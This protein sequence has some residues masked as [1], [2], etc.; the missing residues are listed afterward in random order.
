LEILLMK[1]VMKF[2]LAGA[3][4][5]CAW[6]GWTKLPDAAQSASEREVASSTQVAPVDKPVATPASGGERRALDAVVPAATSNASTPV[7]Q[8][9]GIVV[10]EKGTALADVELGALFDGEK[11]V[12]ASPRAK[13][14]EDGRFTIDEPQG[15]G[16]LRAVGEK[17][18]TLGASPFGPRAIPCERIL[19]VVPR[20]P[21]EGIVVDRDGAPVEGVRVEIALFGSLFRLPMP[22]P[23]LL[24]FSRAAVSGRDGRYRIEDAPVAGSVEVSARRAGSACEY[25]RQLDELRARRGRIV[26]DY[27]QDQ[28]LVIH[29]LVVDEHNRPIE[30]A[31]IDVGPRDHQRTMPL[32]GFT[33]LRSDSRGGFD[34]PLPENMRDVV[35]IVAARGKQTEKIEP[36]GDP[37]LASSWPAPF[38][39]RL[40]RPALAVRGSVID[41]KGRALPDAWVDV[42]DGTPWGFVRRVDDALA[43]VS[44]YTWEALA[45]GRE[46]TQHVAVDGQGRFEIGELAQRTYRIVAFDPR[47]LHSVL[48]API[49]AGSDGVELVIDTSATRALVAGRVVDTSKAPIAGAR[50]ALSASAPWGLDASGQVQNGSANSA[51][52]LTDAEGRFEFRGVSTEASHLSIEPPAMRWFPSYQSLSGERD[53]EQLEITLPR[54]TFLQLELSDDALGPPE[55]QTL[56]TAADERHQRVSNSLGGMSIDM[57]FDRRRPSRVVPIPDSARFLLLYRAG[58]VELMIPIELE[59]GKTN[60]VRR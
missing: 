10:D 40:D 28:P 43:P 1:T 49:A 47:S 57:I 15:A 25:H 17:W 24:S 30:G 44:M 18:F 29:G 46:W 35:V 27:P 59:A 16:S 55:A 7:V 50:V 9:A 8:L 21:L 26:F 39:I 54:V 23:D 19:C 11:E 14:G 22:T 32:G 36:A 51:E 37:T 58:K 2:A 41:E 3:L 31:W 34:F 45:A 5:F 38:T 12:R 52:V 42:I 56:V 13:S 20:E 33:Q 60:L 6:W 48:S 4:L 53:L